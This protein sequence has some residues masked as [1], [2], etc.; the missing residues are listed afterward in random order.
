MEF[1]RRLKLGTHRAMLKSRLLAVALLALPVCF[2]SAQ[3]DKPAQP[4]LEVG[5][6]K[7]IYDP[8]IGEKEPW[9]I[10]DHCFIC[11]KTG[12]WHLFGIT[13][14][15]PARPADE[16]NFAHATAT[17]LTTGWI[18]K[19]FA[20]SVD[21]K[22]GEA[23]LWAPHVIE[24]NG[25]YYMYYCA[26]GRTSAEYQIKLA[27]SEDLFHWTRHPANPMLIDGFD[28]RD[29]YILRLENKW[30]M[31]YTGT[32]QP[33]GGNH[34]VFVVES[35]NL[36]Q[37]TNK[38]TVFTDPEVGTF[39]GPTESPFV[40]RRGKSFYLFIGP[41]NDYRG[42]CVYKS[43]S[44]Y[45]FKIE[46]LVAKIN[47]HAAEVIRDSNGD[48]YVSHAGWG[49]GGVYLAPLKWKDGVKDDDASVPA[50]RPKTDKAR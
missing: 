29:P 30:L 23:H 38:K 19:P 5:E 1:T 18:K 50:P 13:R 26:G 44:P 47:S 37:W 27:T 49:Q 40:V 22:A 24:H 34:T 12:S 28:A 17:N 32:T 2:C 3:T 6:F 39:G 35:T 14:E 9:Y 45:E 36:V 41:R 4:V 43:D 10:N 16:D 21:S 42:T 25:L 46:N 33:K 31:Y 11:D 48:W 7:R 8:S 15:E 20:L